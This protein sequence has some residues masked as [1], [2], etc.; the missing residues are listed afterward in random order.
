MPEE[1]V[2]DRVAVVPQDARLGG[3]VD[4]VLLLE[5]VDELAKL[6][7]AP[8]G[9]LPQSAAQVDHESPVVDQRHEDQPL[10][11]VIARTAGSP[12]AG[13]IWLP[14]RSKPRMRRTLS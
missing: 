3:L 5:L 13:S 7:Q 2:G 4:A 14:S 6:R 12:V 9:A 1:D 10:S 8:G 11:G